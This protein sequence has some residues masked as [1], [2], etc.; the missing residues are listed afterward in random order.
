MPVN[1]RTTPQTKLEQ[2]VQT[3]INNRTNNGRKMCR[4]GILPKQITIKKIALGIL[5]LMGGIFGASVYKKNYMPTTNTANIPGTNVDSQE[6]KLKILNICRGYAVE[7]PKISSRV[8]DYEKLHKLYMENVIECLSLS[9]NTQCKDKLSM[10]SD[11]HFKIFKDVERFL[12]CEVK[13]KECKKSM[14]EI[15]DIIDFGDVFEEDANAL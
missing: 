15:R 11:E 1:R 6:L 14:D 3:K 8:I 13:L 7:C 2:I 12:F 5:I 4:A 10:Q 9:L